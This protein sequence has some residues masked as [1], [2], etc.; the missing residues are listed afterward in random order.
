MNSIVITV[1]NTLLYIWKLLRED[2]VNILTT[3]KKW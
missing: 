2:I 3:K 1:K